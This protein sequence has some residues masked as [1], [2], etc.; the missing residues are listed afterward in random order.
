MARRGSTARRA[1]VMEYEQS[2]IFGQYHEKLASFA[3][4]QS[5]KSQRERF[6]EEF[7]L[8]QTKVSPSNARQLD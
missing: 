4:L 1:S 5:R 6:E 8:E 7:E 3:R 2:V